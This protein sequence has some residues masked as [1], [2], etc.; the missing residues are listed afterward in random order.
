MSKIDE[1]VDPEELKLEQDS[2]KEVNEEE[3][4]TGVIEEFGFDP[5]AD[6]EKIEKAVAKEVKHRKTLSVAIGQKVKIRTERDT[7]KGAGAG[8][9]K[10]GKGGE[11]A[12][13]EPVLTIKDSLALQK[14]NI[15]EEDLDEVLDYAKFK[16]VSVAEALKSSILQTTLKQ[17]A[18][19][20]TTAEATRTG[21]ARAGNTS[22]S[23]E[24][25]L[26]NAAKGELP[27][28]EADLGRLWRLRRKN[29]SKK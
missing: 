12:P 28:D 20:R 19:E 11:A 26:A 5:E 4:R 16:K 15:A 14:A 23:D 7:L 24:Q 27:E 29:A 10:G 2:L 1:A 21:K 6:K 25:L 8:D 9:G 13:A 22:L 17:R 18:E 3:V